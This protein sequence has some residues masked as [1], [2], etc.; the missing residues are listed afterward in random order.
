MK[1]NYKDFA[2]R[3]ELAEREVWA[4]TDKHRQAMILD[5]KKRGDEN[6]GILKE[7]TRKVVELAE[8]EDHKFITKHPPVPKQELIDPEPIRIN[9]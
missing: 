6:D 1:T 7:F 4:Q 2:K 3:Y 5:A 8:K 9:C